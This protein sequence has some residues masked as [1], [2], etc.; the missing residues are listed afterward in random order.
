MH[1]SPEIIARITPLGLR[2]NRVVE[3]SI[4]GL[5]RSP[6]HG[7]SVEFADYREY[8][9]G[10]DLRRLDWRAYA[11]SNKFQIK[12]YEEESNLRATLLLDASASMRYGRG[13]MTKFDYAA[14]LAASMAALLVK[15][16]DAVGLSIFD[17]Q[18]RGWLRPAA[19]QSQLAKIIDMLEK[20]KPD[21]KTE[22]SVVM[23]KVADQIKSRGLVI[24][25][26]D[27]LTDLDS[28]YGGLGRLQ[29]RGHEILIF[30]VLDSD[31]IDMPFKDS[32]LFRDIEG[33]AAAE[34][35]FA[36]PWAFRKA[37]K[38]AMETF[39]AEVRGRC[40]F[41]G[42]DHLL[43]RTSDDLGTALSHYLHGRHRLTGTPRAGKL[44]GAHP[45]PAAEAPA[46]PTARGK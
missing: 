34:E 15:Q 46:A 26:S 18:E 43:L 27:L 7:V 29:Y 8:S 10:D 11:R 21:R 4:S 45:D 9:P 40:Q 5:H 2:A 44:T 24:V 38:A 33:G 6:L 16:R 25:I 41:A 19:T 14:T 32:V 1:L 42:I 30:Q 36:E 12:R 23:N 22:L 35:L 13:A 37:Y 31:E 17:E 3:G 28:F 20:T 39:I